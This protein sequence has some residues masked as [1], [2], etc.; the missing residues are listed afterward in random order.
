MPKILHLF[1]NLDNRL[2]QSL[3]P[4]ATWSATL[5]QNEH[6]FTVLGTASPEA[7]LEAQQ[8]GIE[9][10]VAPVP[11]KLEALLAQADIVQVEYH[12]T[13]RINAL[14]RG[15]LPPM[16]LVVWSHV[17]GTRIPHILP[18]AILQM[19]DACIDG[20]HIKDLHLNSL[21]LFQSTPESPEESV[22]GYKQQFTAQIIP[23]PDF[24]QLGGFTRKP[25]ASFNIGFAAA[26]AADCLHPDFISINQEIEIAN[27]RFILAGNA[28]NLHLT[29]QIA[30]SAIADR[31]VFIENPSTC[32][33]IFEQLDVFGCPFGIADSTDAQAYLQMA[34]FSGIPVVVFDPQH[35]QGMIKHNET[36]FLAH[37][38]EDYVRTIEFLHNNPIERARVGLNASIFAKTH[39]GARNTARALQKIYSLLQEQPKTNHAWAHIPQES[40]PAAAAAPA[41][42]QQLVD[43]LD[44][45]GLALEISLGHPE[46]TQQISAE[47]SIANAAPALSAYIMDYA[48]YA[49]ADPYLQLWAGLCLE[50]HTPG[51][52]IS[53]FAAAIE[54]GFS[55]W[56]AKWYL[57]R[58]LNRVGKVNESRRIYEGLR[59]DIPDFNGLTADTLFD[60]PAKAPLQMTIPGIE[61]RS[62]APGTG[63]PETA[64]EESTLDATDTAD[65]EIKPD[66]PLDDL[67][68]IDTASSIRV[69]AIVSTYAS[70]AFIDGCLHNLVGQS[71]FQKGELE[72]IV[73]DAASP[74]NEKEI[75]KRYQENFNNIVYLRTPE[76]EGLY[77]SWN[78]GIKLAKGDYI[79]SANT[80][81]RHRKDAL[82]ILAGYL[83]AHPEFV[84]LYP[85]QIDTSVPNE[86]FETSTSQKVLNW[87]PYSYEELERH[88]IIGSQPIWRRT[89]HEKYGYFREEFV[90]AGDYEFWLRLG[91]HES[92]FRYP[93]TLGLYYRNP[94]GIE[95]G[96]KHSE[97][98][99][100]KIWQEYGM[101]ERGIPVILGGRVIKQARTPEFSTPVGTAM[102]SRLPFDAYINQFEAALLENKLSEAM[103]VA[104]TTIK[105]YGDLPYPQILRAIVLT[106]Q[107]QFSDALEALD[108]S[109]Q[110]DETPEALMEL[111]QLS[112]ASGQ[113]EEALRTTVY[114]EQKY[115]SWKDR[116]TNIKQTLVQDNTT[117]AHGQARLDDLDYTI[118]SL[119][120]LKQQFKQLLH[121]KDNNRAE[122]LAKAAIL[123]FPENH[124]AWVL[125]ATSD[126]LNGAFQDAREAIQKSLLIE[127]SPEALIELFEV[128]QALGDEEEARNIAMMFDTAYPEYADSFNTLFPNAITRPPA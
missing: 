33:E 105:H 112:I 76:R 39:L 65:K 59:H 96:A 37:S 23:G 92:F 14:L 122:Q 86:T 91:R 66:T 75:V 50:E 1:E 51:A 113:E 49:D 70:E 73:I 127:D 3:V 60:T 47:R 71:L 36:G 72:I 97:T 114:L 54:Q 24:E 128:S 123:K 81:D 107:F 2:I 61:H 16:R 82:E 87:P 99:T 29:E 110:I 56:R 93:E 98:E 116:L 57:A 103:A 20:R 88:C 32:T 38:K 17:T 77:A 95:H 108:K 19:A 4:A 80:D 109:I 42:S 126:R 78:R 22:D 67:A 18:H 35:I 84:L 58:T 111:I 52:A 102:T 85:G 89:M 101:F 44:G 45:E 90:S 53:A 34:M 120:D 79:T 28:T 30:G 83:D 46:I 63:L 25:H 6:V 62:M 40:M 121:L 5:H 115:P 64:P 69:S 55:H 7:I 43:A 10:Y 27:A 15:A 26:P 94:E 100:L 8:A 124:E 104:E 106:K 68:N 13:P 11:A 118:T 9:V 119:P 125:K 41:I 48:R 117:S 74:E 21:Q 31:F 12:N